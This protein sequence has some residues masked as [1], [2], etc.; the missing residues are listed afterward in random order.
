MVDRICK[1][2]GRVFTPRAAN[3]VGCTG[4][5]TKTLY[6]VAHAS[7]LETARLDRKHANPSKYK[8][9][10]AAASSRWR[11]AHPVA[12]KATY[13][14]WKDAHLPQERARISAWRRAHLAYDCAKVAE[15]KARKLKATPPWADMR[16]IAAIYLERDRIS[17]LTGIPHEVDHIY[18]LQGKLCCGLHVACNLRIIPASENRRKWNKMPS[19]VPTLCL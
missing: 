8:R 1:Q 13:R 10:Q 14:K 4:V 15:R 11:A 6:K 19:E 12:A 18:P 3:Q 2:C 9:Q 7:Q 16:A 5:C 17:R